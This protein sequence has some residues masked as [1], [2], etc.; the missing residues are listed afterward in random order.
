MLE[1][2]YFSALLYTLAY[3]YGVRFLKLFTGKRRPCVDDA[4]T[5]GESVDSN[6]IHVSAPENVEKVRIVDARQGAAR[7]TN[8]RRAIGAEP[9]KRVGKPQTAPSST[10]GSAAYGFGATTAFARRSRASDGRSGMQDAG[11]G[12]RGRSRRH[13]PGAERTGC[14]RR[15]A[16]NARKSKRPR[17]TANHAI[18]KPPRT[19]RAVSGSSRDAARRGRPTSLR[20]A[21]G[22]ASVPFWICDQ[23]LAGR[24]NRLMKPLA[25]AWSKMSPAS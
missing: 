1:V 12:T 2:S 3:I 4:N 22:Y 23:V 9:A 7:D 19:K 11:S 21:G 18:P 5:A 16:R 25:E 15:H 14:G 20:C 13:D 24:A 6:Q 8:V 17:R 10:R